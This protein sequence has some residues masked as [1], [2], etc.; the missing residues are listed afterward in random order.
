MYL[1]DDFLFFYFLFTLSH[2]FNPISDHSVQVYLRKVPA[3]NTV[4]SYQRKE[5]SNWGRTGQKLPN[6]PRCSFFLSGRW[7]CKRELC[8]FYTLTGNF[9]ATIKWYVVKLTANDGA[10]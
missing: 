7:W 1:L 8:G 10:P 9:T 5:R 4:I 2:E 6:L 3:L